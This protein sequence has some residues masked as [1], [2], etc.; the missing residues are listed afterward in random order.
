MIRPDG[1]A[2]LTSSL[3]HAKQGVDRI[4]TDGVCFSHR[5]QTTPARR[6]KREATGFP[7]HRSHLLPQPVLTDSVSE[8]V[9][10][11]HVALPFG[12]PFDPARLLDFCFMRHFKQ[13][14]KLASSYG[15]V[16]HRSKNHLI[17][18]HSGS[19]AQVVT[20]KSTSDHRAIKNIERAFKRYQNA[21]A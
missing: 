19:G 10:L 5:R 4:C 2:S 18:R 7:R 3:Y 8:Q 15:F 21:H 20:A 14:S 6:L 1:G 11:L 12:A 16:L 9:R 17:W 13:I